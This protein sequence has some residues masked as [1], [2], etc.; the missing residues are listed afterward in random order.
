MACNSEVCPETARCNL[1]CEGDPCA[2]GC[3]DECNPIVCDA[4]KG[5]CADACNS[6]L[7]EQFG[8]CLDA[9]E[10][11]PG[12]CFCRSKEDC[13]DNGV[14]DLCE[15]AIG[16]TLDCNHDEIPDDCQPRLDFNG[17]GVIDLS[18]LAM[19]Q[20]C[21]RWP[22]YYPE[23]EGCDLFRVDCD[24]DVDERDF[25]LLRDLLFGP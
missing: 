9:C 18:D 2:E 16:V 22:D 19:I 20:N 17:N 3:P 24:E 12:L 13:N 7:C 11:F 14:I 15:I 21:Y 1:L 25:D 23:R 10:A 5:N 6:T 4:C 8:V